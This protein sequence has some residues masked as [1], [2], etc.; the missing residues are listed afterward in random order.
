[1]RFKDSFHPYAAITILFWSLAYVLTRITLEY[2]SAFSLGF[3]RYAAAS[4]ALLVIVLTAKI[5][6]PKKPDLK[7]FLLSGFFGFFIYMIVF[8]KGCETVAAATSSVI[9]ATVPVITAILARLFYREKMSGIQW[10][11]TGL[12]FSGVIVLTALDSKFSL[13]S[14]ILWLIL[15]A[16]SLSSYNLLQRKLT[17]TYSGLQASAYSIFAGTLMLAVFIPDS[18]REAGSA[19]PVQLIY[20][21]IL[22]VFSS[23]I[24]YATWAQAIKKAKNTASVSNYMF[25]TPFLTTLLGFVIA[26]EMPYMSTIV[27]GAIIMTGVLIFNFG[28]RLTASWRKSHIMK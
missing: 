6:A 14:G 28:G 27:G 22:G 23:A 10:V 5:K 16:I 9:I 17:K 13:N 7:W 8:N 25:L 2:F 15:A 3:L 1:M 20:I 11:A 26:G 18:V 21:A 19:P 4:C 12:E 24:A